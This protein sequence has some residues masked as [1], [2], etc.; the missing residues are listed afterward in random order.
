ME[1]F[2]KS[3]KLNV[4][5][6]SYLS[7]V[8]MFLIFSA[9]SCEEVEEK[10]IKTAAYWTSP[11]MNIEQAKRLAIHDVVIVDM[12][13]M[14]NNRNSLKTLKGMN[15]NLKL[16]CY[17]NPM[18]FFLP[19]VPNRPIQRNWYNEVVNYP[20]WFLRTSNGRPAEFWPGMVMMNLSSMCPEYSGLNYG[21]WMADKLLQD[22]LSDPLW[23]GYFLDNGGGNISWLYE[24]KGTQLDINGNQM[25]NSAQEIDY[26]WSQGIE[27]FL[28]R[29]RQ[30]RGSNF[31]ITANKGSVEMLNV[32]DGRMFE[33]F[34][35][36][37]LGSK[38]NHG[39]NQSMTNAQRMID[40]GSKYVFFQAQ[41]AASLEFVLASSMLLDNVYFMLGQDNV[42]DHNIYRA[43]IGKPLGSFQEIDGTYFRRFT[44]GRVE[45]RPQIKWA[46]IE[47]HSS[48]LAQN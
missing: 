20:N 8:M 38:V 42:S 39:W 16:V 41:S 40:R 7:L 44:N 24:G 12:E 11:I 45:V 2:K 46:K 14:V 30:V 26:A 37:Y 5:N 33:H 25:A 31:I 15:P 6:I 13:N 10:D 18:E 29:I 1:I 21:R 9:N 47:I 35:N 27:S 43:K 36:D 28:A 23:D 19:M 34:P 4:K 32:L 17:S 48:P 22:V 3:C